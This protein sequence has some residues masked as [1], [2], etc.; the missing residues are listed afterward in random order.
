MNE[1]CLSHK[2]CRILAEIWITINDFTIMFKIFKKN[3]EN[4]RELLRTE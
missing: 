2:H 4:G 3:L 1:N